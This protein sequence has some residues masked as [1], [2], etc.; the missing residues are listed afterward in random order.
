[1][2]KDTPSPFLQKDDGNEEKKVDIKVEEGKK[3]ED[4]KKTDKKDVNVEIDIDGLQDRIINIPVSAG[5]YGSFYSDGK[6]IYYSR[7][8]TVQ[9]YDLEKM[10]ED[11]VADGAQMWVEPGSKKAGFMKGGQV[12]VTDIP[13]G[14]ANLD[15]SV[16]LSNMKIT[17][18]YQKEWAQIFDEAWRVFRDGFYVE[19]MHGVDWPAMKKKYAVLVPHI[20]NRLDLNYV[21]GEMISE[22]NCGHAYITAGEMDRPERIRTGLLGAEISRD[23]SGFFRLGKIYKG[24]TWSRSLRSPLTEPGIEAK[25]GEFIVAIDGIPTNTVKDL[26]SLLIGKANVP[27]EITLNSTATLA[28]ARKIVIRPLDDE[29]SL[30]HYEWVKKNIEKVDKAS[31]G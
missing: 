1:M 11:N 20:K 7:R 9:M 24:E 8:G 19:N 13:S 23:K 27:T 26:Y 14:K 16:N 15:K 30:I 2:K 4:D 5:F 17:V 28:G 25:T 10:K 22:L 6:K 21:V 12:Y 31:G 3:K 29:N 18:D